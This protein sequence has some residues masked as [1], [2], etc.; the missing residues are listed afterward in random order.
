MND[1]LDQEWVQL[2]LS[3]KQQGLSIEEI[4]EFLEKETNQD[5]KK[6]TG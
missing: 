1:V 2:I 5:N 4:R 3:A 6:K